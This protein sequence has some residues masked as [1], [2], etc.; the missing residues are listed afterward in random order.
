MSRDGDWS[1]FRRVDAFSTKT[2][3]ENT[4]LSPSLPARERLHRR[5]VST[6]SDQSTEDEDLRC[7]PVVGTDEMDSGMAQAGIHALVGI[8][9]CRWIPRRTWMGLGVVL[10]SMLPDADILAMAAATIAGFP[11][12]RL[13][14]TFTHSL[15]TVAMV[16]L[17]FHVVAWVTRHPQWKNLGVGLGIGILMHIALDLAIWFRGV[18]ILW[19]LK[20]DVNVWQKIAVPGWW[21]TF[22][23]PAEFLSFALLFFV[24]LRMA[25]RRGTDLSCH[26]SGNHDTGYPP[27]NNI[28]SANVQLNCGSRERSTCSVRRARSSACCRAV[29]ERAVKRAPASDV[30]PW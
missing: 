22:E 11:A 9:M 29:A 4:D 28:A 23:L 14:R 5:C 27:G 20:S 25:G 21:G 8:G 7:H 3:T 17:V 10:G 15:F 26:G 19:P 30:L 16:L 18:E 1:V 24:L 12:E 6:S 13:H 2:K